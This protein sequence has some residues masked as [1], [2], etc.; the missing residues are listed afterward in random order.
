V[1]PRVW[2]AVLVTG[3]VCSAAAFTVQLWGQRRIEPA[4]AAVIL[5]FEPVVA[6]FVGYAVGERLGLKGYVGAAVIL[7]SILVAEAPSWVLTARSSNGETDGRVSMTGD[8]QP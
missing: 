1:T 5:L 2:L 4:R 7:A 3:V 6:G 8:H